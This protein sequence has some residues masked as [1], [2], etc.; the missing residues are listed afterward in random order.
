[1]KIAQIKETH[2][3]IQRRY[4]ELMTELEQ[5]RSSHPK[6]LPVFK[7]AG[8]DLAWVLSDGQLSIKDYVWLSPEDARALAKWLLDIYE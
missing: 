7:T 6:G 2:A 4:D 5:I 3:A 1:M 8:Q